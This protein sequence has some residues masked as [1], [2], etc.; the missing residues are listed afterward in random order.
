M[1]IV[2]LMLLLHSNA[3][4]SLRGQVMAPASLERANPALE[5]QGPGEAGQGQASRAATTNSTSGGQDSTAVEELTTNPW[6]TWQNLFAKGSPLHFGITNKEEYDDNIFIA[7]QKTGDLVTSIAPDIDFEKGDRTAPHAAYLNL[8]FQPTY[9]RYLENAAQNREDYDVDLYFQYQWTRLTLGFEQ[10]YQQLTDTS[11]DVINF[12]KRNVYTTNLTGNYVYNGQLT[13]FGS[14][15][16]Q[17]YAFDG[18]SNI[19]T[20]QWIIDSY[21]LYQVAP[22]L[23]LGGGPRIGFTDIIGAPNQSNQDLL[24]HLSYNPEGKITATLAAGLEYLEYQ[25]HSQASRLLPIV[26]FTASYM[27][28][29]G[30]F[31]TFSASRS[32]VPSYSFVGQ[33]IDDTTVDCSIRQRCL[34]DVFITLTGSYTIADYEFG[35]NIVGPNRKDNYYSAGVGLE[36]E[37][38]TWLTV[39]ITYD[40][41]E[42]DSNLAANSFQD[43]KIGIRTSINF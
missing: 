15:K 14:A 36:W 34:Q 32:N 21:A 2:L 39:G 20:N 10:Q 42:D 27:P 35:T 30:T 3:F 9:F 38:K 22:K 18:K 41:T 37:P 26:D 23:A 1:A 4:S 16:Q 12:A 33:N 11:I 29:D 13:F 24:L 6:W 28:R 8:Y 25:A 17:I 43:N 7:P 19:S 31:L 40:R 5:A